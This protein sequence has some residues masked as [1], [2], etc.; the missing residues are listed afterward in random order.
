LEI[1]E[2]IHSLIVK[3]ISVKGVAFITATVFFSLNM[4]DASWWSIFTV[5]LL[6]WR[7]FEKIFGPKI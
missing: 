4:I 2:R 5:V 1:L 6:G 7:A 3:L